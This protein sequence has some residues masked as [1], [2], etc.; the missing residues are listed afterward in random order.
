MIMDNLVS[1]MVY[2]GFNSRV[3]ALDRVEGNVVWQW[4]APH[5]SGYVTI[6]V[7]D[8]VS[9]IVSVSGYTYCLDPV[10][11]KQVW[12]NELS[13][14]GTGVACIATLGASSSPET[15]LGAAA[16]DAQRSASASNT[17]AISAST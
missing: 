16:T 6:L 3:A 17:A 15:L 5:G 12:Y 7:L 10:T 1:E 9:M 13:G 11:G 4:K 8:E 14:M 2:I